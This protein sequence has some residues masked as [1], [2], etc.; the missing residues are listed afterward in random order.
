[1]IYTQ[2]YPKG[3]MRVDTDKIA[4]MFINSDQLFVRFFSKEDRIRLIEFLEAEGFS[5]EESRSFSRQ[6]TIDS[7]LPLVIERREKNIRCMGN[8]TCAAAAAGSGIIMSDRDFYL[9]YSLGRFL[10]TMKH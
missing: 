4:T 5:C 3:R 1:M 7:E 6:A 9:L 8:A 2:K 10:T